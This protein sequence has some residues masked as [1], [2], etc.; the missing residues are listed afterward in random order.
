MQHLI[1]FLSVIFL[2]ISN[3]VFGQ[4]SFGQKLS[5]AAISLINKD[6]Q[7]DPSYFRIEYPNGDIPAEKGVCTDLIIRAYRI[8][9]IDLQ[10]VVHEDMTRN[11]STY[12]G[13]WGLTKTDP[14]IDHR[15]VPNL[16]V[17]FERKGEKLNISD[18]PDKYK[19]GDIV[20]WDLGKGITHIGIVTDQKS[21][22]DRP[23]IMHN[24][25]NGQILADCLFSY[26]I[27]GHYRFEGIQIN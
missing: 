27:I 16:M 3:A 5:N 1:F 18:D 13:N 10:K 21:T 23:L 22:M 6:I 4:D 19:P 9:G 2:M 26:K 8:T 25:G 17:F 15:R 24:I 11:F 14:N 12:P 7:Y 20:C